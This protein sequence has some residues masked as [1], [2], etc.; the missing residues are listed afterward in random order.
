MSKVLYV[1]KISML[2]PNFVENINEI[3]SLALCYSVYYAKAWLT[4]TFATEAP[5]ED[6]TFIKNLEKVC[7]KKGKM[8][9]IVSRDS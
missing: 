2:I 6:I 8:G 4:S 1:I 3:R 7:H 9:R 5:L